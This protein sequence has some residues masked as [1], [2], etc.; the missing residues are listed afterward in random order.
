MPLA[1]KFLQSLHHTGRLQPC[2]LASGSVQSTMHPSHQLPS[3]SARFRV[4]KI[5][6]NTRS[7]WRHVNMLST[8]CAYVYIYFVLEP[9][10]LHRA[11]CFLQDRQV[12][13]HIVQRR[14]LHAPRPETSMMVS[15]PNDKAGELVRSW[16]S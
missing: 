5:K 10:G 14:C 3:P 2:S 12:L 8:C 15:L 1:T 4:H 9:N 6:T 11:T 7:A 16:I 13:V